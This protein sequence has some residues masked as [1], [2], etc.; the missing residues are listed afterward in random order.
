MRRQDPV[1][2]FPGRNTGVGR[3]FFCE[4]LLAHIHEFRHV[5][6]GNVKCTIPIQVFR[7]LGVFDKA[8]IEPLHGDGVVFQNVEQD[9]PAE[10]FN[11]T[12]ESQR[13]RRLDNGFHDAGE[14]VIFA[15]D[16][17]LYGGKD[18]DTAQYG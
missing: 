18:F 8:G 16:Q 17:F 5:R 6:Y 2:K 11:S 7:Q 12:D 13:L 1:E 15:T 4:I 9:F 3:E 10:Q 14:P